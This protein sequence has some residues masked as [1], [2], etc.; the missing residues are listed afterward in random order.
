MNEP[1]NFS[2]ASYHSFRS[3]RIY[4][5]WLGFLPASCPSALCLLRLEATATSFFKITRMTS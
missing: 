5:S 1:L 3:V 4:L 2:R